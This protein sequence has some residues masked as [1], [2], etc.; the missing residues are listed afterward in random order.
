[1]RW[2]FALGLMLACGPAEEPDEENESGGEDVRHD[3]NHEVHDEDARDRSDGPRAAGECPA[4]YG[5]HEVTCEGDDFPYE[6]SYPEGT[7]RCGEPMHCGGAAPEPMP[8]RWICEAHPTPCQA[9]GTR[10]S[11]PGAVCATHPCGWSG[12]R[13]ADGR[14]QAYHTPGPP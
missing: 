14:W 13:C 2:I 7:C 10:C 4:R 9:P 11:E 12:V 3:R 1:M 8:P 6:C 5:S